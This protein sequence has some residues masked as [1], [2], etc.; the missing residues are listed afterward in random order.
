LDVLADKNQFLPLVVF[1]LFEL[2]NS[3]RRNCVGAG[4]SSAP[5]LRNCAPIYDWR[6]FFADRR[7]WA[8]IAGGAASSKSDRYISTFHNLRVA[9]SLA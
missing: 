6:G 3:E 7:A 1:H 9:G 5:F 4:F 8:Q 2:A